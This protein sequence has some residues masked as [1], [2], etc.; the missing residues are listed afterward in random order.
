MQYFKLNAVANHI[1]QRGKVMG[2]L[3]LGQCV[4]FCN[5]KEVCEIFLI[6]VGID[7]TFVWMHEIFAHIMGHGVFKNHLLSL[8]T[9]K[10]FTSLDDWLDGSLVKWAGGLYDD[11]VSVTKA[12]K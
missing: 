3:W 11:N 9:K 12:S 8:P 5:C 7:F 2:T 10:G 1:T 4:T 6:A